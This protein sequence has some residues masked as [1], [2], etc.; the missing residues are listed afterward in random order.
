MGLFCKA[1]RL[2]ERWYRLDDELPIGSVVLLGFGLLCSS[3]RYGETDGR[4]QLIRQLRWRSEDRVKSNYRYILDRVWVTEEIVGFRSDSS[5][6]FLRLNPHSPRSDR[7]LSRLKWNTFNQPFEFSL[8]SLG[9]SRR[10]NR[11]LA[12]KYKNR[13]KKETYRRIFSAMIC[14]AEDQYYLGRGPCC[15]SLIRLYFLS[16]EVFIHLSEDYIFG[17][18]NLNMDPSM[19]A[20]RT[21]QIDANHL[22]EDFQSYNWESFSSLFRYSSS[23]LIHSFKHEF[24]LFL[25]LFTS[26]NT[27][28][29]SSRSATIGQQLLQ[30]KYSPSPMTRRQKLFYLFSLLT[31]YCYEKFLVDYRR[32]LPFQFIY[33]FL[34]FLNFLYF[35]H[36]GK[37]INLFERLARLPT[38]H[39]HPPSLRILDYSF[40][41]REL[42]WHTFNETLGTLIP[43]FTSLKARTTMRKYLA[44]TLIKPLTQTN[45][46]SVCDQSMVMPHE[47]VGECRHYFCYICAYSLL[48]QSCPI[49]FKTIQSIRPKEFVIE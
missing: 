49:C 21:P 14:S 15:S 34:L 47:S 38:V 13:K 5:D 19:S 9:I 24:Q 1:Q 3:F 39:N 7:C 16:N 12:I 29:S 4:F 6:V 33:K 32:L 20:L 18:A 31:S 28:L 46:C 40:M 10:W 23:H 35:L 26:S 48:D 27:L 44:G 30:I 25:R 22:D 41:K 45:I 11:R 17:V 2:I 8:T 42:I 37:Y 43:F 36:Q